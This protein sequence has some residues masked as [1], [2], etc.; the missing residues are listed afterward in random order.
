[1][2]IYKV[3]IKN[4]TVF[5]DISIKFGN[6]VNVIIGENGTGKTHLLKF[7]YGLYVGANADKARE[8]LQQGDD[9]NDV[10][11]AYHRVKIFLDCFRPIQFIDLLAFNGR[12]QNV[13]I[14]STLPNEAEINIFCN[15]FS[16]KIYAPQLGIPAGENIKL[17]S[18]LDRQTHENSVFIPAKEMLT[19]SNGLVEMAKKYSKDMPFDSTFLDVITQALQWKID[20]IT[21]IFSIL[22]PAIEKI[23]GGKIIVENNS[24]YIIKPNGQRTNFEIEAEGNKKLGLLWQLIMNENIRKSTVLIWDE[25]ETNINP[26][27]IPD[28]VEILL[29]LSRQGVQIFVA[30]HDYIFAKYFEV[31]Q[32]ETDSILFHSLYKNNNGIECETNKNFRDLRNNPI[33]SAFDKLLDEV[34]DMRVGE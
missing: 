32:K 3:E 27:L 7:L 34:Y 13:G 18:E 17:I 2:A 1:M 30:T 25:P 23:I 26:K 24:F 12:Q 22:L 29:E 19:H 33:T 4:F 15:N 5:K 31:R 6:A 16:H 28:I 8:L 21:P 9:T 10:I 11:T 14:Y 20:Y